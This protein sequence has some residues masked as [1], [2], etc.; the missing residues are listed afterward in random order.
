MA[1]PNK[2]TP[3]RFAPPPAKGI[4]KKATSNPQLNKI[5]QLDGSVEASFF[6]NQGRGHGFASELGGKRKDDFM[7]VDINKYLKGQQQLQQVRMGKN[8]RNTCTLS[9]LS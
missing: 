7:P 6:G 1:G 8:K 3:N 4:L 5:D 2:S 9:L